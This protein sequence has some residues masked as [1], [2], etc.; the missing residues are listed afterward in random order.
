MVKS[1]LAPYFSQE[2]LDNL[3]ADGTDMTY[4]LSDGE[5]EAFGRARTPEEAVAALEPA[6]KYLSTEYYDA[7]VKAQSS[8]DQTLIN[9]SD[10]IIPSVGKNDSAIQVNADIYNTTGI[11]RPIRIVPTDEFA[12]AFLQTGDSGINYIQYQR[13]VTFTAT[14]NTATI[15]WDAHLKYDVLPNDDNHWVI[16]NCETL[17]FNV[18]VVPN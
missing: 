17:T 2:A 12:Y 1:E 18:N 7:L 5:M 15:T 4:L 6:K 13:S 14:T 11:E 9:F 8:D 10:T 3:A 16:Y